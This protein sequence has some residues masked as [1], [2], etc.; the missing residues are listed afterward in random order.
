[1]RTTLHS[2]SFS[3]QRFLCLSLFIWEAK[4]EHFPSSLFFST[5]RIFFYFFHFTF[6]SSVSRGQA[7]TFH[8]S[9]RLSFTVQRPRGLF[10]HPAR[11]ATMRKASDLARCFTNGPNNNVPLLAVHSHIGVWNM[12]AVKTR[13]GMTKTTITPTLQ[14]SPTWSGSSSSFEVTRQIFPNRGARDSL[15]LQ[16]S[17]V[18]S[19]GKWSAR[20]PISRWN[21]KMVSYD[22]ENSCNYNLTESD[23]DD[24]DDDAT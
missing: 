22:D 18:E 2:S 10:L 5:P 1:M 3:S 12:Q 4:E 19:V 23:D 16:G 9:L 6:T 24:D 11:A 8:P 13:R 7:A 15:L 17:A 14:N 21:S 20:R